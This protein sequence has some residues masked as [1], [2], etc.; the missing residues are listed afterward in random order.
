MKKIELKTEKNMLYVSHNE[1]GNCFRISTITKLSKKFVFS[2]SIKDCLGWL[3][4]NHPEL[5]L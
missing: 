4:E 3:T 2:N 5:L 1:T